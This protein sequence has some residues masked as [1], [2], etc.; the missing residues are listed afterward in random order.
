M[1]GALRAAKTG[2]HRPP[3]E[4]PCF[5]PHVQISDKSELRL[6]HVTHGR[7][8]SR[9]GKKKVGKIIDG[10]IMGKSRSGKNDFAIH[11][12]AVSFGMQYLRSENKSPERNPKYRVTNCCCGPRRLGRRAWCSHIRHTGRISPRRARR[13]RRMQ[14]DELSNR[15]IGCAIE[16]TAGLAPGCLSRRTSSASRTN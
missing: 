11:D 2:S 10:R 5:S 6:L 9:N 16:V 4:W 8:C 12:F 15:V 13:T 3:V 14:F 1:G 7:M